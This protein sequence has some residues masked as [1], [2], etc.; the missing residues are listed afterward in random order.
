MTEFKYRAINQGGRINKGSIYAVSEQDLSAV[1]RAAGLDLIEP[2]EVVERRGFSFFK[3]KVKTRDLIQACVHLFQL[4]RAGVP[5]IECLTEVRDSTDSPRL[6]DALAEIHRQVN[7]GVT[8][9]D[10]FA[11][12]SA[13]FSPV[14]QSLISAG[15][16][17]GKMSEA[18]SQLV[19]HL[20]WNEEMVS[21]V[22]KATRYPIILAVVVTGVLI[23]MMSFVVPQ[24]I[25]LLQATGST[26]PLLTTALIATSYGITTYWYLLPLTVIG[27]VA[28]LSIGRRAS[29]EFRYQTD[30]YL[31]RIPYIG[32][33]LRKIALARFTH[34]FAVM[35]NSGLDLLDC[36]ESSKRL[37]NN[38]ALSDALSAVKD[39]V[40]SGANLSTALRSTGEFPQLVLR[41]IKV[42]EDSGNM[43][44][45][46]ENVSEMYNRDV[47]DA[48]QGLITMIEPALTV[49]MGGIMA[50]IVVAVFG[51]V[52]DS[53]GKLT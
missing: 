53:L 35:F 37:V 5:L 51:P 45:S 22:K 2:K 48:I 49:V 46:L 33:V 17:T 7:E 1:L 38:L 50:W 9:S 52:Y 34:M 24:I 47:D 42:G 40:Q 28:F 8:L 30:Y 29:R 43:S 27:V 20:K 4:Q 26:L 19:D 16:A 25:Q 41:M 21:K 15:E 6:R 23:F 36:L 11:T 39:A 3:P 18:F 13:V 10:A 32:D 31:L 12:H 14:F 44:D